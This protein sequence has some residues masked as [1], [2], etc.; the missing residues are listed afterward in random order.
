[1]M[2][3]GSFIFVQEKSA[4]IVDFLWA[5]CYNTINYGE[6]GWPFETKNHSFAG[7]TFEE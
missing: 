4:Q 2:V 5:A 6:G 7:I 3:P 1:V